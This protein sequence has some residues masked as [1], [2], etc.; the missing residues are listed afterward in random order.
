MK[1]LFLHIGFNKT[2]ST[3]LQRDLAH[4]A[5]VLAEQGILYPC[6]PQAPFMQ[7]WQHAPLAAAVPGRQLHW[8][9]PR[10][11][12]TLDQAYAALRDR[13]AQSTCDTLIL[14][15][16]GFGETAMGQRKIRWLK[17]Q[18]PGLDITVV[19][20]VRRQDSYFLSTYQEGIK[21]G[22]TQ[23][24]AFGDYLE[25]KDLYF[26]RR[27]ASWRTVFGAERV[28]V[29]PF[30]PTLWPEGELFFDFLSVIG[31]TSAGMV[32]QP[33]ENEGFDYRAIEFMR[34]LNLLG[35][36]AHTRA[37][38]LP[39][40][41]TRKLTAAFSQVLEAGGERQKMALASEQAEILRQHFHQDN[42]EALAG[43]GIDVEDFFPPVPA[44]R[45]ARLAPPDLDPQDL[46]RLIA[47]LP[48]PSQR[49]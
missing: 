45:A 28:V 46:L 14:S 23:P 40:P 32:P 3:S 25:A 31:A 19:A 10:K 44:G 43:S 22:R 41:Q 21:A 13:I 39:R 38:A 42:T 48:P 20:Y 47:Q 15:S 30:A 29:R 49:S 8:L 27:L 11:R 33:P 9:L 7:R 16:E 36:E 12:D 24:F 2:G 35:A 26:G 5:A 37:P 18:F 1:K 6:D 17:D 4:N 34:Q